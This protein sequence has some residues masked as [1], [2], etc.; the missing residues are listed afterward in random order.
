MN[1]QLNGI[2]S[3]FNSL[4]SEFSLDFRLINNLSSCFYFHWENYK[5][6]ESKA[7]HLCKLDK[8]FSNTSLDPKSVII[9]SDTSIKNN[10]A[11]SILYIYFHSNNV[12]KTIYYAINIIFTKAK[13][14]A[15]KCGISQAIQIPDISH[16]IFIINAIYPTLYIFDFIVHLFQQQSIA[17]AK[18]LIFFF[19]KHLANSIKF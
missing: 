10:I 16:I 13:L 11:T 18:D 8:I 6:K 7:A 14:F 5:D 12:K 2:F 3:S 17:I 9:I 1:N 15:I 19:L 4:N